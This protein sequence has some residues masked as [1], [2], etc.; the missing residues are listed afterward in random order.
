MLSMRLTCILALA[1]VFG[2]GV[3]AV[4]CT[5]QAAATPNHLGDDDDDSSGDD[6][7]STS[8]TKD[9]GGGSSSSSG[10]ASS[11]SS[12]STPVDSGPPPKSAMTFFITSTPA[13]A[14]GSGNLGGLDG[15]DKK[16]QDLATAVKGGDHKW[17]AFLGA[18]GTNPKDRIGKGP[19]QNQKGEVVSKDL[20]GL[21]GTTTQLADG[22]FVDEKGAAV[23]PTGRFIL[24]GSLGDGTATQNNCNNWTDNTQNTAARF[25]D[26]TP[27]ANPVLGANWAFANKNPVNNNNSNCTATGL[28]NAKSEAR[29]ACFATD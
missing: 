16:C 3:A 13:S 19:W 6:D 17:A 15:A 23:P 29:I 27:S 1:G 28:K 10:G 7:D 9:G 24:T 11:S 25:G 14:D 5:Q 8:T 2:F 22:L 20:P 21:F 4:A 18:K 12:G 26:T